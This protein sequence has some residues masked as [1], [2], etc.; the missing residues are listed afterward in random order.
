MLASV[1]KPLLDADTDPD[2]HL[3]DPYA[4]D[5]D[6]L[7]ELPIPRPG[8]QAAAASIPSPAIQAPNL[9]GG[10][11]FTASGSDEAAPSS[12]PSPVEV[13]PSSPDL[14][15]QRLA[16]TQMTWEIAA[17]LTSGMLANPS[18]GH[19][20][21][22]DAMGLFDQ[23]LQEMNSYARIAS[24]FDL[25]GSEAAR[26]KTHIEYFQGASAA[27]AGTGGSPGAAGP[28]HPM[29]VSTP[30]P[31]THSNATPKPAPTKP[32]PMGDYRP[33][34]PCARRT[35]SPGSMAGAPPPADDPSVDD[36]QAA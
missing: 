12:A 34:P 30:E 4:Y 18:R 31:R 13:A 28:T 9:G 2:V 26:R 24:E 25:F 16:A 14:E 33:I 32:R 17:R 3:P 35:Y 36:E 22:K 7:P 29:P 10:T 19:A 5:D 21:V 27:A 23:F 15:E 1:K 6:D 20:S 8:E 11:S